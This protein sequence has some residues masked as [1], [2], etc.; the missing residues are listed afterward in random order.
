MSTRTLWLVTIPRIVLGAIFASAAAS[1]FWSV[2]FGWMLLPVPIT[3]EAMQFAG[4]IIKVGYLWPLMKAINLVAGVLLIANRVPAL[5]VALL[6]PVT[7]IIV[8]FQ[9]L[10]NPLPVPLGTCA[11]AVICELMLLRAY[12]AHFAGLFMNDRWSPREQTP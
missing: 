9:I 12:A 2:M 4:V 7:V 10:L 11:L 8:W 3:A 6:L 5:A 1:Y